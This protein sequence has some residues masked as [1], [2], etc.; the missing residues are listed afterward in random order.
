MKKIVIFCLSILFPFII[1][2][3]MKVVKRFNS[4]EMVMENKLHGTLTTPVKGGNF[5]IVILIAGSG[6]TDRNGN[7]NMG[8]STNGYEKL[9]DSLAMHGIAMFRYDKRGVAESLDSNMK[10]T[11]VNFDSF[12]NDAKAI[13]KELKAQ[14]QF[15]KIIV[16]GHSE[17]SLIGMRCLADADAYISISGVA[18]GVDK[19]LKTQLKGKL[20]PLEPLVYKQLDS[21]KNGKT[22]TCAAPSLMSLFRPSVQP[23]M[24]S[25]M[26]YNPSAEIKKIKKPILIIQ[27]TKDL[28]VSTINAQNLKKA[29]PKAKLVLVKNMNH[30]LVTIDGDNDENYLSYNEPNRELTPLLVKSIVQFCS[31]LK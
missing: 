16:A 8:L 31:S 18:E 14:Q 23:F 26:Q 7:N 19:T 2:A 12:I 25:W 21:L 11:D 13:I 27:G 4:T 10:E 15:S 5:P 6:P 22:V 30:C 3:R 20:G 9:A 17:G 24:I 28:Q 1:K 29:N